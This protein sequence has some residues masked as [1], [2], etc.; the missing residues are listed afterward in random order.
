MRET[1]I[2]RGKSMLK[3]VVFHLI[4]AITYLTLCVSM[5][6]CGNEE[7][8]T[9][10]S[11]QEK[12]GET[13]QMEEDSEPAKYDYSQYLEKIWVSQIQCEDSDFAPLECSFYFKVIIY[14]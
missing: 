7:I 9:P 12:I 5:M 4:Y 8:K 11:E 3:K 10:S 1:L 6:G 14:F 13:N 2:K